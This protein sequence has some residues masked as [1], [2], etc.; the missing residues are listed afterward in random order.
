M[1]P[2]EVHESN[3]SNRIETR[4]SDH[5]GDSAT[6]PVQ[7]DIST[8]SSPVETASEPEPLDSSEDLSDIPEVTSR[9]PRKFVTTE[10]QD[11]I[12][13]ILTDTICYYYYFLY[14]VRHAVIV[15]YVFVNVYDSVDYPSWGECGIWIT[16][17]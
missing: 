12:I 3:L 14:F 17:L 15:I 9:C 1:F 11:R 10:A 16:L 4:E 2:L 6:V 8:E 7:E 5:L 13:G